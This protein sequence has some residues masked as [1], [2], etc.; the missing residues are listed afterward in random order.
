MNT[1]DRVAAAINE[2]TS[3][4]NEALV[5]II[6]QAQSLND[7]DAEAMQRCLAATSDEAR[8]SARRAADEAAFEAGGRPA[9]D[10]VGR[11][12]DAG[13]YA[14][15]EASGDAANAAAEAGKWSA[16]GGSETDKYWA[17]MWNAAWQAASDAARAEAARDYST[18]NELFT[19]THYDAL[20]APWRAAIDSG[21]ERMP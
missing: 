20:I 13:W 5:A 4:H 12:A 15:G 2:A 16:L 6:T 14:A 10:R 9:I 8:V 19:Q 18:D 3:E 17:G 11:V 21:N 1:T 7:A